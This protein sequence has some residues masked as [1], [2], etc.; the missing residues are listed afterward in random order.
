M[1]YK[2]GYR[3][4]FSAHTPASLFYSCSFWLTQKLQLTA[5]MYAAKALV[6]HLCERIH[7]PENVHVFIPGFSIRYRRKFCVQE[8]LMNIYL[9]SFHLNALF[10]L[11]HLH[12]AVR[13]LRGQ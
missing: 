10:G 8:V 3:K 12:S 9:P 13:P 5:G 2:G 1:S 7:D 4:A 6:Q 11:N